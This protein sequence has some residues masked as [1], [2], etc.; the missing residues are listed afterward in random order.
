[1]QPSFITNR[2]LCKQ[3]DKMTMIYL[4]MNRCGR[5]LFLNDR[6]R[7]RVEGGI[8]IGGLIVTAHWRMTGLGTRF[9]EDWKRGLGGGLRATSTRTTKVFNYNSYSLGFTLLMFCIYLTKKRRVPCCSSKFLLN[10]SKIIVSSPFGKV[11]FT[12]Y[13]RRPKWWK[14]DSALWDRVQPNT[15]TEH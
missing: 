3:V 9:V 6:T 10:K 11:V 1:M 14:L 7:S 13:H 2:A 15:D 12:I 5:V 4:Y 8:S